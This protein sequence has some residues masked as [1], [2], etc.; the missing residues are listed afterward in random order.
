MKGLYN[1][2]VEK[3][4]THCAN[5]KLSADG[6][7]VLCEKKGVMLKTSS[8]KHY[9]YDALKRVPKPRPK[10]QPHTIEEFKL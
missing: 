9:K 4:C 7:D 1:K 2:S 3:A 10:I 5:G 8:C 6:S